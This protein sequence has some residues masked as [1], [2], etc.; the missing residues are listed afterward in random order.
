MTERDLRHKSALGLLKI[1][2]EEKDKGGNLKKAELQAEKY[3]E[4]DAAIVRRV[5]EA[6]LGM[7]RNILVFNDEAH[8]AYRLRTDDS[9]EGD[10]FI[11]DDDAAEYYYKEAT[12]WVG[13]FRQ[14]EQAA[15]HQFLCRFFRDTLFSG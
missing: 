2:S 10:N 15:R 14:G 13:R 6:E 3:I 8:H 5:L 4:S 11:G 12:V 9:D 7:Q 1:L